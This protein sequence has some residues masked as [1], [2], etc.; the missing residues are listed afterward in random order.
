M[1]SS[2]SS[3][4]GGVLCVALHSWG[5][6]V[7]GPTGSMKQWIDLEPSEMSQNQWRKRRGDKAWA[8]ELAHAKITSRVLQ[9]KPQI[10]IVILI[11]I[12]RI[13]VVAKIV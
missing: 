6:W 8:R 13:I 12:V 1:T 10:I 4:S 9:A 11:I 3:S 7:V 5:K 2:S